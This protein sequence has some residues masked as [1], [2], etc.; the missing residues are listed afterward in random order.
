MTHVLSERVVLL[1]LACFTLCGWACGRAEER[2]GAADAAWPGLDAGLGDAVVMEDTAP[3]PDVHPDEALS[4][5]AG[6]RPD[7]GTDAASVASPVTQVVVKE[8]PAPLCHDVEQRGDLVTVS[9]EQGPANSYPN[10]PG[11][12]KLGPGI[13]VLLKV[14]EYGSQPATPFAWKSTIVVTTNRATTAP[15]RPMASTS[16]RPTPGGWWSRDL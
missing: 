12:S 1:S 16:P 4:K 7:V 13:Y 2:D 15:M 5:D 11:L 10:L 8:L 9:K 6:Q 3:G 14:T